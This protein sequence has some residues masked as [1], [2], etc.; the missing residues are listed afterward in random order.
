LQFVHRRRNVVYVG[1]L[2]L[3]HFMY[4]DNLQR[5]IVATG[6]VTLLDTS[7]VFPLLGCSRLTRYSLLN[8]VS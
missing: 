2:K 5:G 3:F 7:C 8:N 6:A 4:V 1:R